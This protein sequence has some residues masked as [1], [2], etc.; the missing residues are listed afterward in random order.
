MW[1]ALSYYGFSHE[2]SVGHTDERKG[3]WKQLCVIAKNDR[4]HSLDAAWEKRKRAEVPITD[5]DGY[6]SEIQD[7][8][9]SDIDDEFR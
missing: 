7:D 3:Y 6:V 2:M 1:Y 5:E 9:E 8:P 4:L